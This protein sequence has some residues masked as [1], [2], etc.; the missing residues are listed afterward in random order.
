VN[1]KHL[2]STPVGM[3]VTCT[4]K[5]VE[6]DGRRLVFEVEARDEMETIGEGRHERFIVNGER[7][8]EKTKSKG[9]S[10]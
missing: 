2:A 7:F 4:A 8:V 1:V 6:C 5:L 10:K 9:A 3:K